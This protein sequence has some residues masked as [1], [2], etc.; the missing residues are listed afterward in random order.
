ML[1]LFVD[2]LYVVNLSRVP[3]DSFVCVCQ[4]LI[5]VA[6]D[7]VVRF[8]FYQCVGAEGDTGDGLTN[9]LELHLSLNDEP[10]FAWGCAECRRPIGYGQEF[11]TRIVRSIDLV[12]V[13]YLEDVPS[14]DVYFLEDGLRIMCRCGAYVGY[15]DTVDRVLLGYF[16]S[17]NELH[18]N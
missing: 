2:A 18:Y 15:M 7:L 3:G 1:R 6:E 14:D 13:Q 12:N 5:G 16:I 9:E 10:E 11:L 4:N 8:D 17:L